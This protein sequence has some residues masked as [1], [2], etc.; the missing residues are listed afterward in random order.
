MTVVGAP[1]PREVAQEVELQAKTGAVP[2]SASNAEPVGSD[3]DN[4]NNL[5]AKA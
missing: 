2:S 1:L 4:K 5:S 3:L